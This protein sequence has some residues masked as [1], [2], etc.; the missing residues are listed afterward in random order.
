LVGGRVHRLGE[1]AHQ[2]LVSAAVTGHSFDLDIV[3]T[4]AQLDEEDVLDTIDAATTAGLVS[5]TATPDR[6]TFS[7]ALVQHTL[8]VDLSAARRVRLHQRIAEALEARLG[9]NPGERIGELATHWLAATRPAEIDKAVLYARRAGD[10]AMAS[11]APGEAPRWYRRALDTLDQQ[12]DP[13]PR[14]RC[15]LLVGL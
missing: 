2:V 7:H 5:E 11:L 12:G 15:E 9:A 10:R 13:D 8:Y 3:A 6:F 14:Q 4:A 1:T